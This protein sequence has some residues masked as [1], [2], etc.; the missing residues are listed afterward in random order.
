MFFLVMLVY[1]D[2][3]AKAQAEVDRVVDPDRLPEVE[4]RER[5]PYVEAVV[6]ERLR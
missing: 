4:D 2:G 3:Q 1:P 5:L 6:N